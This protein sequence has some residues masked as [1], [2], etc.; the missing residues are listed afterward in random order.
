V[1][2]LREAGRRAGGAPASSRADGHLL[3]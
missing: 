3:I 2:P 1:S